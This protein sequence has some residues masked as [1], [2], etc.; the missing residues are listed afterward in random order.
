MLPVT[1]EQLKQLYSSTKT[2]TIEKYIGPLNFFMKEGE[3][4]T[5]LRVCA[6]LAQIGHESG[7]LT[8][9]KENLN[10]SAQ[11]LLNI[12][13][14]YFPTRELALEY[15]RQPE[16]IANYVYGNRMGNGPASTGDGWRYRGRGL[17]QITG[18]ESY[19]AFS[20]DR[21]LAFDEITAYLET[22]DGACES[23][24]W[25]WSKRSLNQYADESDM[26]IITKKING[27]LN[28]IDDR[29]ARYQR[30]LEVFV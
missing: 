1:A 8:I 22:P 13:K 14:K 3:I 7:G 18:K 9:V 21:S 27:G 28:G 17:I 15:E 16:K 5:R 2:E 11:G 10:Y 29:I 26:I 24:V 20:K 4:N 6:F 25:F 30:A 23:A 12:F 19:I